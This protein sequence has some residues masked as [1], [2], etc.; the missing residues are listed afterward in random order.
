MSVIQIES[1]ESVLLESGQS[2]VEFEK[3]AQFLLALKFFELGRLSAGRAAALCSMPRVD[4]LLSAGRMGVPVADLDADEMDRE[5][6][7]A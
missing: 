6:V 1:P 7:R 4:F 3:E 5:F 2:R